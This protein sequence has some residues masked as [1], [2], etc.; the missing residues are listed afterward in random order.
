MIKLKQNKWL[1]FKIRNFFTKLQLL[2][3][4]NSY[5]KSS[6]EYGILICCSACKTDLNKILRCRK[7]IC[8][9][10]SSKMWTDHITTFMHINSILLVFELYMSAVFLELFQELRAASSLRILTWHE[11]QNKHNTRRNK[12][13]MLPP[14]RRRSTID[15]KPLQSLLR[16]AYNFAKDLCLIPSY[17]KNMSMVTIL[18]F[19]KLQA[20]L[21]SR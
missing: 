6:I 19:Q 12:M 9:I 7:R 8:R 1:F 3:F 15:G 11:K 18:A 2:T 14:A 13:E 5:V 4:Y 21:F 20:S 17:L 16:K 10:M